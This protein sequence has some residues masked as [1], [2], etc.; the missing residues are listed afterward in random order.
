MGCR[1]WGRTESDTT[2]VTKQQQQ[3]QKSH[4]A[5]YTKQEILSGNWEEVTE[6]GKVGTS[7]SHTRSEFLLEYVYLTELNGHEFG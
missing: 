3:Q 2:E 6:I 1:L 5:K 7:I 4:I